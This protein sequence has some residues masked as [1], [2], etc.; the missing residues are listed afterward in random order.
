MCAFREG[1]KLNELTQARDG[2]NDL[3]DRVLAGLFAGIGNGFFGNALDLPHAESCRHH[4]GSGAHEAAHSEPTARIGLAL[5][6]QQRFRTGQL[7]DQG[8]DFVGRAFLLQEVENDADGF[9]RGRLIDADISD[10]TR[11]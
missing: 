11:N 10:E 9:F 8:L 6:R 1:G 5:G 7:V 3:T 4:F 2:S